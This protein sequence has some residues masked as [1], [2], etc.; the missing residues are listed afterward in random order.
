M[1]PQAAW[2]L[3]ID[4]YIEHDWPQV[5][6]A[7][8][9][10]MHWID[11]GGFPPETVSGRRMGS[12]WNQHLAQSACEFAADLAER[13]LADA[14]GIPE[15]VPF[16]LSCCECDAGSPATYAEAV[17]QGW[18]NIEFAPEGLAENFLGLCPE[19]SLDRVGFESAEDHVSSSRVCEN[20]FENQ[21]E[22][23]N[24]EMSN[25]KKRPVH[26][27]RMGRIRAAIWENETQNGT[28]HN[29]TISRLYK[30]GDQWKDSTSYGRDDLPLV[31]KVADLAHTWIFESAAESNG[32]G[33][34]NGGDSF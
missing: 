31:C 2:Q 4:S 30:D 18:T 23:E 21:V 14:N 9:G 16:S 29:V 11:R 3:L 33:G 28:R 13:V 27:I 32:N 8:E 5:L 24:E 17:D 34:S 15:G 6:E 12:T 22:K 10:L 19:H 20:V 26:E 1:D 7:A 25:E